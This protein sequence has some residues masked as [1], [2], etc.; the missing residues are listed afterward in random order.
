[1]MIAGMHPVISHTSNAHLAAV[2][3]NRFCI[4]FAAFFSGLT[5]PKLHAA[6]SF[7][8]SSVE[9]VLKSRP[10]QAQRPCP[11]GKLA[12]NPLHIVTVLREP[13]L[14]ASLL[15]VRQAERTCR[16]ARTSLPPRASVGADAASSGVCR[17]NQLLAATC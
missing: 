4:A 6:A 7:R 16:M 9:E 3:V 15:R 5:P 17:S 8:V 2:K 10:G 1:M 14:A 12:R 11:A 13:A